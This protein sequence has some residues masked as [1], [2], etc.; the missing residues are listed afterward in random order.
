MP[1]RISES[2][3]WQAVE[4]R[5]QTGVPPEVRRFCRARGWVNDYLAAE[6]SEDP[7]DPGDRASVVE[8]VAEE[9]QILWDSGLVPRESDSLASSPASD[10]RWRLLRK[11]NAAYHK[12]EPKAPGSSDWSPMRVSRVALNFD[13]YP[14]TSEVVVRFDSRVSLRA[15]NIA[16]RGVWPQLHQ[17]GWLRRSRPLGERALALIRFVCL[18]T[19]PDVTWRSRLEAW[20]ASN[21]NWAYL[22]VRAF[23]RDF[24][25]AEEELTG[26]RR[27]LESFYNPLARLDLVEL[28]RAKRAGTKGARQLITRRLAEMRRTNV[29]MRRALSQRRGG[30]DRTK[31][32]SRHGGQTRSDRSTRS[33]SG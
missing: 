4:A 30:G 15:L 32:S 22:G 5:L 16:L 33:R 18:E 21:P 13:T 10:G 2:T 29:A 11:L 25:R 17:R 6:D 3:L 23:E 31:R 8:L 26:E 14:T 27:S 12:A 28:Y 24:R 7:E 20:N 19:P 1:T 9:V